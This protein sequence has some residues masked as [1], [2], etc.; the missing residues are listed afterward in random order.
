MNLWAWET[1]TSWHSLNPKSNKRQGVS[2]GK[3]VK[4]LKP[5][6]EK[7]EP[8][9]CRWHGNGHSLHSIID[10]EIPPIKQGRQI[11][12]DIGIINTGAPAKGKKIK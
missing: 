6:G 9:V 1:P 2:P 3:A 4:R 5:K 12:G 10:L 8:F 11:G 7:E